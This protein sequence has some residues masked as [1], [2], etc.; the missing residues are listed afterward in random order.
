[1]TE[2]LAALKAFAAG[3]IGDQAGAW[4][5]AGQLPIGEMRKLGER[6]LLCAE[7]PT[8]MGGLGLSSL[9][10]GELTSYV[11]SLCSSTR[12]IM[13]SHGMAAWMVSRFGDKTQ[14]RAYLAELTSGKLAAVGF[15]EP[16]AGSDLAALSTE[17]RTAGD[18]GDEVVLSGQKMWVTGARYADYIMVLARFGEAAA[19]VAVPT[20]APGVELEPIDVAVLGCRAAGHINVRLDDVRLPA[21]AVLGGGGQDLTMLFTVALSY[22]RISVA[23]G[24]T[25][26]VRACLKA[27]V[28][29]ARRREQSG[30]KIGEHQLVARHLAELFAAEQV[31]TR[32]C[33]QASAAWQAYSP[34]LVTATVLAKHVAAG[35]AAHGSSTAVQVLGSAGAVDGHVVA[36]AY[37][38]SK[39]MEIIEGSNEISQLILAHH[40]LSQTY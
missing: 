20:D 8:A 32:V 6:G 17:L 33:E 36:R 27:A 21:S 11:G 37:R 31:S 9:E 22:G 5:V 34:D 26:I 29:H 38:D 1:M 30:K 10:N 14:R 13:T 28:E 24:C 40:A 16:G 7:V 23:W 35:H 3:L 4:D 39:V 19:V 12:S 25:G 15:S 2:Q 18:G